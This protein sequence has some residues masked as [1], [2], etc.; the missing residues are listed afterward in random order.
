MRSQMTGMMQHLR[1]RIEEQPKPE[2]RGEDTQDENG[3]H[4]LVTAAGTAMVGVALPYG[5][6]ARRGWATGRMPIPGPNAAIS[7]RA[8]PTMIRT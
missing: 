2:H 7:S 1:D 3:R 4:L 6:H 5:V 8:M